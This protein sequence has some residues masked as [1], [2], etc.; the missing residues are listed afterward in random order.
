MDH[1]HVPTMLHV[2]IQLEPT[3][4]R[5]KQALMEMVTL[6]LMI[7]SVKMDHINVH[8]MQHVITLLALTPV[9]A[10]LDILEMEEIALI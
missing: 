8:L 1:I 10:K 2:L 7:M 6:A 5:A 4:V 9:P 3:L